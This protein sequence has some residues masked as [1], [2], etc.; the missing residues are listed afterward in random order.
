[1]ASPRINDAGVVIVGSGAAG[2]TAALALSPHP[3][4]LLTKTAGL[5]GGSSPY[6]Q[7]GIAAAIG[8]GDSPGDH[9]ADTV[10]AG[11]G[12]TDADMA[13]L[14]TEGGAER[15]RTLLAEG[16][17]FDRAADG[18]PKLGR[19]A[20]HGRARIVHAGGD[21]T[22]RFLVQSLAD[23]VLATPSI[24]VETRAFALDLVVRDGRVCGVLAFHADEGW[25]FHRTGRVVLATGGIG[26]AWLHTTNPPENTGDGLAMAARAGAELGDLEFM[27]FHPTALAVDGAAGEP[28]P[29]LTEALR[30]AGA[31][32]LDG[33]GRRF[34]P[35]EHP[36]AELAPRDVVARAVWRHIAAGDVVRLDLRQVLATDAAH[37]PTVLDLCAQAG[38]DPRREPVPVAPA[39]HYHMGGIATDACGRT[40]VEGLWACGEAADTG[41]HGANRLA[42][43]SLLEGLVFGDRVARDILACPNRTLPP[44]LL[45]LIP[46]IPDAPADDVAALVAALRRIMYR[47]V[48]LAR[49]GAGLAQ[50][51]ERLDELDTAAVPLALEPTAGTPAYDAPGYDAVMRWGELSNL[52]LAGRLVAHA[53]LERTESRGA[54]YRSDFPE[55]AAHWQRRRFVTLR[56]LERSRQ[57][58]EFRYA[59][60]AGL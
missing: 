39:A 4:T 38:F 21:A 12:I 59:L 18:M 46:A 49:D 54:H 48:G 42:S 57:T 34:M 5:A 10:A 16:V 33:Q 25:V 27:Q 2:L 6:A 29:L 45:P 7:G 50:A 44:L 28:M 17:P 58:A 24:T 47:H 22:G 36:D 37:F 31:V 53:A 56:D 32:L 1:M 14:L 30:G 20:A 11:A 40:S 52:L 19:E 26:A 60:S 8:P 41:V 35:D 51:L 15:V 3:V 55:P 23:R 13:R 43:N 9:A